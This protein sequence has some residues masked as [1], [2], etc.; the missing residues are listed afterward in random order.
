VALGRRLA[1]GTVPGLVGVGAPSV[2]LC[3]AAR[4]TTETAELLAAALDGVVPER[5][6]SLYGADPVGILSVVAGLDD[7]DRTAV[8]VGHNPGIGDLAWELAADDAARRSIERDG[9]ATA[10]LAAIDVEGGWAGLDVRP[11]RL[12][13]LVRPPY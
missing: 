8:V 6:R 4:R 3:S 12:L 7:A 13:T 2:V 5:W 10:A 1:D 9:F 11:T